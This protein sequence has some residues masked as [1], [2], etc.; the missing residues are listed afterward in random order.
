MN[1]LHLLPLQLQEGCV[2]EHFPPSL[3]LFFQHFCFKVDLSAAQRIAPSLKEFPNFTVNLQ[4][5]LKT[6]VL[7]HK[8]DTIYLVPIG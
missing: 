8:S 6:T 1:Y 4:K 2:K 7:H 3:L 5:I